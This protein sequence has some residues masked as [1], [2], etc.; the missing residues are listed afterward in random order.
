MLLERLRR[1]DLT[2]GSI[3]F[4]AL[5]SLEEESAA[6]TITPQFRWENGPCTAMR[7]WTSSMRLALGLT[8][9]DVPPLQTIRLRSL[10][11]HC[12]KWNPGFSTCA[13]K[14]GQKD[15]RPYLS[16]WARLK[17]CWSNLRSGVQR[18]SNGQFRYYLL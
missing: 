2:A 4:N 18:P 8:A 15:C 11:V 7:K 3:H 9:L 6:I 16:H 13:G 10:N 1:L 17:R 5:E 12:G 14:K